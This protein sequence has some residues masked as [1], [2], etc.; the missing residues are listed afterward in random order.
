MCGALRGIGDVRVPFLLGLM[1]Y[2]A[3]GGVIAW[4]GMSMYE[5]KGIWFGLTAGLMASSTF[6]S[7]RWWFV[8]RRPITA[9]QGG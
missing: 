1:S 6:L 2:W 5:V 4:Y 7:L 8:I 9:M 3:V